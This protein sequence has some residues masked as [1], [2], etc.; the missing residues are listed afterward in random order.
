MQVQD[1]FGNNRSDNGITVTM[2]SG[3]N[4]A[5]LEGGT[6]ANTISGLATFG[7]LDPAGAQTTSTLIASAPGLA[8]ATSSTYTLDGIPVDSLTFSIQPV[9]ALS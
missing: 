7:S 1:A 4:G 6:T 3:G 2:T 5:V 9:R 8:S